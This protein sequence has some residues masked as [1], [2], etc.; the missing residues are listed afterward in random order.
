MINI[1]IRNIGS[2][3]L[4]GKMLLLR[5]IENNKLMIILGQ[6]RLSEGWLCP[7]GLGTGL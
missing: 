6:V 4:S 5:I 1:K 2:G 3:A 7:A